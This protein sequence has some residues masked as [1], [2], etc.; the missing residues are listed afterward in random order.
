MKMRVHFLAPETD[1]RTSVDIDLPE[2]DHD[3]R[4]LESWGRTMVFREPDGWT[5]LVVPVHRLLLVEVVGH[6]SPAPDST[7]RSA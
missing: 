6:A 2:S 1:Q 7:R 5:V 4:S 3:Q